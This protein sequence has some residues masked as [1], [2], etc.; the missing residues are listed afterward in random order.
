MAATTFLWGD[1]YIH[2]MDIVVHGNYAPGNAGG[3]LY[4]DIFVPLITIVLFAAYVRTANM[5]KEAT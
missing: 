3:A 2:I 5:I 4:N 1:A